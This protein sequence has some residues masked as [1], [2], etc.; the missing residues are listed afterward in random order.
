MSTHKIDGFITYREGYSWEGGPRISFSV[1]DPKE[2]DSSSTV[3]VR[4]HSF[5]VEIP[6]NFD[7]RP[8]QVAALEAQKKKVR[9]EFAKKITDLEMQISK[10]LAISNDVLVA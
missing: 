6:D 2:Y 5:E 7:P 1:F 3:T 4:P 9:A 8:E 10:L